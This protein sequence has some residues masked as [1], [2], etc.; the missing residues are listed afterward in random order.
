[1]REEIEATAS[2]GVQGGEDN[3]KK[4][5]SDRRRSNGLDE[6]EN[7][8]YALF[9][10]QGSKTDATRTTGSKDD[11]SCCCRGKT[12]LLKEETGWFRGDSVT[13]CAIERRQTE[14]I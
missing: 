1:M 8:R 14:D 4:V 10:V 13:L 12:A 11:G 5:R 6:L 2:I 7:V 9:D 3:S